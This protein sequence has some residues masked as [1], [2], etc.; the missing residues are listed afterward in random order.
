MALGLARGEAMGMTRRAI[1]CGG[2]SYLDAAWLSQTL[3]KM[4]AEMPISELAH[5][6]AEGA[7]ALAGKWAEAKGIP[8]RVYEADWKREGKSAGPRRNAR[9]L[10]DFKPDLVIAFA[11]GAGTA[12]MVKRAI[13]AGVRTVVA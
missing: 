3:D 12:D 9:M 2:R 7:D 10:K 4:H 1:V 11:G 5:G 13:Q 8:V 6:G